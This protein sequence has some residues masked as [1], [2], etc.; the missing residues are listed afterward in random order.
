M[1][2]VIRIVTNTIQIAIIS[3]LNIIIFL[4]WQEEKLDWNL[5]IMVY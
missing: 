3:Y 5:L 4:F 2:E 1:Q